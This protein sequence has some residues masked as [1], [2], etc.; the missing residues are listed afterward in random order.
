MKASTGKA[1]A[2]AATHARV[3]PAREPAARPAPPVA[4]L[5]Q[6]AGNM[7][8]Q[9]AL[10]SG[11]FAAGATSVGRPDEPEERR[12]ESRA[13]GF[14]AQPRAASERSPMA[15]EGPL[16][17]PLRREYEAFF[18]A[19][20]SAVRIHTGPGPERAALGLNAK[21]FAAGNDVYF[22]AGRFAPGSSEGRRLLAHE[23]AHVAQDRTSGRIRRQ[24]LEANLS[25]ADNDRRL[26]GILQSQPAYNPIDLASQL[27]GLAGWRTRL[28]LTYAE[29]RSRTVVRF[30]AP[31]TAAI[32]SHDAEILALVT[33]SE[34]VQSALLDT[35]AFYDSSDTNA[36]DAEAA[37]AVIDF[38]R[39]V[40]YVFREGVRGL[41]EVSYL[42]FVQQYADDIHYDLSQY[43]QLMAGEAADLVQRVGAEAFLAAADARTARQQREAWT[44]EG[45]ALIGDVVAKREGIF[46]DDSLELESALDPTFGGENYDDMLAIARVVGRMCAVVRSGDRYYAF[47]LSEDYDR[48]DIFPDRDWDQASKLVQSGSGARASA[49]VTND[50]FVVTRDS[51]SGRFFGAYP[52]RD[53]LL[54]LE[55]D[56]RLLESGEAEK[57]GVDIPRLFLNMV[58]NLALR[59]LHEAE[60][61][62]NGIRAQMAPDLLLDPTRGEA[63]QRD[64]ARLR[65]LTLEAQRLADEIGD[66]APTE[67]QGD[68]RDDLLGEMGEL[69]QRSPAAAFLV[70]QQRNTLWQIG[71]VAASPILGGNILSGLVL[72][73]AGV[74]QTQVVDQLEGLLGGDAAMR[75]VEEANARKENI[76]KVRR[77]MFD[78]PDIVL[79]FEPLH[80]AV[81][82]HFSAGQRTH[83]QLSLAWREFTDVAGT[84]GLAVLD[85]GLL[86]GG[87]FTGGATWLGLGLEAAGTTLA[88]VQLDSQ[89]RNASLLAAESRLDVPGGFQLAT[90]E[91]AASARNWAI[92]GAALTF[93]GMVGMARSA[94]RLIRAAEEEATLVGRI[95]Q[96]AGVSS[97]TVAAALRRNWRGIPNPDPNA[98]RELLLSGLPRELQQRYARL[99]V[100]VLDEAQWAAEFG[101]NSAEHAATRFSSREGHVFA[102]EVVFRRNGNIF[103]M[104][105]E[106][107]HIAQT[108]DP[109]MMRQMHD[110]ANVSEAAWQTMSTA[111]RLRTTRTLLEVELDAQERLLARAQQAGDVE[112]MDDIFA[113]MESITYRMGDVDNAI[114]NPGA[115][116]A[117]GLDLSRAPVHL[118]NAPRLPRSRGAWSGVPGNSVWTST[119]PAVQQFAPNGVRFRNGY[120]D[121]RPWQVAEVRIGQSGLASD[122]ADADAR[123]AQR[124]VDGD[125]P[126]P[127]G[128]QLSDFMH[129]GQPIAAGVERYRR[130]ARLTWHHHQGGNVM[131]LVPTRLHANVPH[132]GGASAAR[133]A[134]P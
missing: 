122:F 105:E 110:L 34:A 72:Q 11:A 59:N 19:D 117:E 73:A 60:Q 38:Y 127:Q 47:T 101:A 50:G 63:L 103:A 36:E 95:A 85:L 131:L 24:L 25:D 51:E 26:L 92:F 97:D 106:A 109:A 4:M 79:G 37:Q 41:Y 91:Q 15:G 55:A 118:F 114:A 2:P 39:G 129:N 23:L 43:Q 61:R 56:T 29:M 89:I 76:A 71:D 17:A 9:A 69:V 134:G 42:Y 57:L 16:P 35:R 12:A 62:M 75:A 102:T 132:T 45:A 84:I 33:K 14:P 54:D 125:F 70:Q 112:A 53:P 30:G 93:L 133:A 65:E 130:A 6:S 20:F 21:A 48:T 10:G 107:A 113:E 96:R 86:I 124:I 68:R 3:S 90:E 82:E 46:I 100:R 44:A 32:E 8:M 120:P 104:Q 31:A 28:P 67:D 94:S 52:R 116:L 64:T 40:T 111:Q 5:Q 7:A 119:R 74:P 18:A 1:S 66:E 22:G 108:I 58:R 49:I 115:P 77:A 27:G 81:L 80:P 128:Y 78:D 88:L 87:F 121:F 123:L 98:L 83:I 126:M 13:E 99:P